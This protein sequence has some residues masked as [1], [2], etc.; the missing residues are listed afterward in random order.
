MYVFPYLKSCFPSLVSLLIT[1]QKHGSEQRTANNTKQNINI[2][3][4]RHVQLKPL[5]E[6]RFKEAKK[7]YF[8]NRHRL[9]VLPVYTDGP[10]LS[11]GGRGVGLFGRGGLCL[12]GSLEFLS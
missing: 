10:E 8:Q 4:P 9:L 5:A 11:E 12:S 7:S 6:I 3:K 2:V 1:L